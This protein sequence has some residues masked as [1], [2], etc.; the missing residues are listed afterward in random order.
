MIRVKAFFA[1]FGF[2]AVAVTSFCGV[3]YAPF[4]IACF[5]VGFFGA[6]TLFGGR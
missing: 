2:L 4:F 1:A 5:G 6:Q 3:P